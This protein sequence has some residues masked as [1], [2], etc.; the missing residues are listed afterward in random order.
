MLL[1]GTATYQARPP[2]KRDLTQMRLIDEEYTG[3]DFT[4]R[5]KQDGIRISMDGRG[6]AFDNMTS[7]RPQVICRAR[8]TSP[9]FTPRRRLA[10]KS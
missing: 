1:S 8:T 3:R 2:S 4:E 7:R 5:L 10:G 9:V 6:R